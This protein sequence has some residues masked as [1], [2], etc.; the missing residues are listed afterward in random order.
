M[1][2][3]F[4]A[5]L[6]CLMIAASMGTAFA[7]PG[8]TGFAKT[9]SDISR[10]QQV[11]ANIDEMKIAFKD[12]MILMTYIRAIDKMMMVMTMDQMKLT[13]R[14]FLIQQYTHM[15]MDPKEETKENMMMYV[16]KMMMS[17]TLEQLSSMMN[18]I[19]SM[20]TKDQMNLLVKDNTNTMMKSDLSRFYI[21][22]PAETGL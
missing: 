8:V 17:L 11:P 2:K 1:L 12:Q 13:T 6:A 9:M 20:M 5:T 21:L 10:G 22:Q 18:Q 7:A 4:V 15:F 16:D 19:L 14:N 3:R